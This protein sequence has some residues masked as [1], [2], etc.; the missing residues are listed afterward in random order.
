M[1]LTRPA[2]GQ[3]APAIELADPDGNIWRLDDGRGAPVLL[4]FHR[5]LR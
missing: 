4:I 3:P 5:H 2:L 1:S